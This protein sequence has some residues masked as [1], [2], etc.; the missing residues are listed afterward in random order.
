VGR[1]VGIVSLVLATLLVGLGMVSQPWK[2]SDQKSATAEVNRAQLTADGVKLQQ[3]A[4]VVEQF[5][6]LN[7]SYAG[8]SLGGLGVRLVRA[9][10]TSYCL[11][12]GSG[13]TLSHLDG[14][15]GTPAVGACQ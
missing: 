7:G 8:A 6:A 4:V 12:S 5:H 3:G 9:D 13:P 2:S 10:A 15:G 11:E 14:P 1:A